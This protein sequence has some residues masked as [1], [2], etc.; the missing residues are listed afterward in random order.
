MSFDV[1][2]GTE[3]GLSLKTFKASS[4]VFLSHAWTQ[5]MRFIGNLILTRLLFPEDFGLIQLVA[6]FLQGVSMLSDLG[7][8]V[9]IIQHKKGEDPHFLRTA[10]TI[11]ILR[12]I[13]IQLVLIAIAYPLAVVYQA[14][15]LTWLIPIAGFNAIID[16]LTSMNMEVAH[17]RMSMAKITLLEIVAQFVGLVA[18]IICAWYWRSVWTLLV[19][20]IV[21]GLIRTYFSHVLFPSPKMA[22]EWVVE[23]VKEIV[24]FGKWIFFSSMGG[25]LVSR[26]DR[27]ILGLYLTTTDLG[28]YGLAIA[29]P[30]AIIDVVTSLS[31]KVL[32][33]LYSHLWRNSLHLLKSQ[34]F[35]TRLA[36][37]GLAMPPLFALMIWGQ[38][39]IDL[40]Y[41][42]VYSQAG[43]MLQILAVSACL[44]SV[45]MNIGPILLAVGDS[46]RNMLMMFAYA[47][48]LIVCMVIGGE[49]FGIKGVIW[50][51][52]ASEVLGYP[53]LIAM[54]KK[55]GVWMPGLDLAGFLLT[56]LFMYLGGLI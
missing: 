40:L 43:W 39:L 51:V 55:Y 50:A 32:I 46:F 45:S 22:L 31:H 47:L 20:G 25:F 6:V 23:D 5:G 44:K 24:A 35:K 49:Y 42:P 17:R 38:P 29:I 10:W 37:M 48:V 26:L 18:M 53:F 21:S 12:G 16:G 14:P 15:P 7:L 11:Q 54:I 30:T 28:L 4:W 56:I 1:N 41:P 33:P 3:S 8:S 2:N 9:N 27:V 34:T 13:L 36:L 19:S 52:P